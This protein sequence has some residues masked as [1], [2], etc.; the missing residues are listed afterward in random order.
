MWSYRIA[1]SEAEARHA[2]TLT[3][4]NTD[5]SGAQWGELVLRRRVVPTWV[6]EHVLG[7]RAAVLSWQAHAQKALVVVKRALGVL[8]PI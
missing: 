4:G 2:G 1:R 5:I 8:K 3:E 7:T 6:R